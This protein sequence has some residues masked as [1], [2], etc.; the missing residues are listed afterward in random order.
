MIAADRLERNHRFFEEAAELVQSNGM[1]RSE[2]HQLVDYVFDRP[3]GE[4]RQ[5]VGGVMVTLAALC[6]ASDADMVAAGETELARITVPETLARIRA[7]Q[8]AKPKHSP[9]PV[10]TA[11]DVEQVSLSRVADRCAG[12]RCHDSSIAAPEP[13]PDA[14]EA[15]SAFVSALILAICE[16]PDRTSPV[17][18]PGAMVANRDEIAHCVG[19]ALEKTGLT[20]TAAVAEGLRAFVS[21]APVEPCAHDYVRSDRVCTEC[22]EKTATADEWARDERNMFEAWMQTGVLDTVPDL[23]FDGRVYEDWDTQRVY[24]GWL[25]RASQA[26]APAEARA[27]AV[28]R[29]EIVNQVLDALRFY[30]DSRNVEWVTFKQGDR[31]AQLARLQGD[32]TW[33]READDGYGHEQFRENG[34]TAENALNALELVVSSGATSQFIAAGESPLTVLLPESEPPQVRPVAPDEPREL[35][36]ILRGLVEG[37]AESPD[38]DIYADDYESPDGDVYVRRAVDLLEHFA[39]AE[40]AEVVAWFE[41][42]ESAR[43]VPLRDLLTSVM[44]STRWHLQ[45][46]RPDTGNP[47]WPIYTPSTTIVRQTPPSRRAGSP[48]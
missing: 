14:A 2:A 11:V 1:T 18:E 6:Q 31:Q 36:A 48:S 46:D 21:P 30:A 35:A 7:K 28:I 3:V 27:E 19:I 34:T 47:V 22:G 9:L 44:F 43:N 5:E 8:A 16:L 23:E 12:C 33:I 13:S 40:T 24:R 37:G 42:E 20:I 38:V 45:P 29:V 10:D 15:Q 26:A 17:D 39:T 41:A 4:M 25:A 32:P